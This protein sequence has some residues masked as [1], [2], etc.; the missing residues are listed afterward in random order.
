MAGLR[1]GGL[2]SGVDT[3]TI[4]GQLMALE[5]QP[6]TRMLVQQRL[7]EGR[8]TALED[9][10]RQLRG[11]ST[12]IGDLKSITTWADVQAVTSSDTSKVGVRQV[13]AAPAGNVTVEVTKLAA[14]E[15]HFYAW[16]GQPDAAFAIDGVAVDLSGAADAQAAATAINGTTGITVHAGVVNGQLVLTG[17]QLGRDI[18]VTGQGG[19]TLA[20]EVDKQLTEYT[21][22]GVAQDATTSTVVQPGGLPGL[23]LTLKAAT[24]GPVTLSVGA[25][26]P[27]AEKVKAKVKAF[28]DAYNATLDVVRG[29]LGEK[30]VANPSTTA[31]FTKGALR[32]DVA[33]SSLLSNMRQ[34]LSPV[35]DT[36]SAIDTLAELGIAPAKPQSSGDSTPEAL[37]GKLTLDAD[38]LAAAL[39]ADAAAVERVLGGDATAIAQRLE[40]MLAPITKA[41]TGYIAEGQ[42]TADRRVRAMADRQIEFDRKLALRE[43]RLRSMFTAMEQAMSASQSQSSW[44]SGQLD[45]L[46][47]WA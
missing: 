28:V 8:R 21:V 13:G 10:A 30:K 31:D 5:A 15:Q 6:K 1:L 22:N 42:A 36:T 20:R 25:P 43:E 38:K 41:G 11:L 33:L 34:A 23:E 9:V 17:K 26:G 37:A 16:T 24:T 44:L 14:V 19:L 35:A 47:K 45:G 7:A 39:T 32:G 3:E 4:I 27:D 12:A 18:T 46:P 2:A 29:K 40:A